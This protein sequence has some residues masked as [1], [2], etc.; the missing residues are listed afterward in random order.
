VNCTKHELYF[1]KV[2][3]KA[4]KKNLEIKNKNI[5]PQISD[6]ILALILTFV[7]QF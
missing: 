5:F 2:I 7:L 1:N 3:F 4:E 6:N